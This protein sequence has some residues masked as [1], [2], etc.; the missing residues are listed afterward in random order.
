MELPSEYSSWTNLVICI[1]M[2]WRHFLWTEARFDIL[3]AVKIQVDVL[4]GVTPCSV[5]TEGHCHCTNTFV[6][7]QNA[8]FSS[9]SVF[10]SLKAKKAHRKQ[11][12]RAVIASGVQLAPVKAWFQIFW[13]YNPKRSHHHYLHP[14]QKSK[15]LICRNVKVFFTHE[16][17]IHGITQILFK[18]KLSLCLTR[19]RTMKTHWGV[20]VWLHAFYIS[21]LDE[22]EWSASRPGRLT[23]RW[24]APVSIGQEAGWASEPFWTRWWSCVRTWDEDTRRTEA[25]EIGSLS[26]G[27]T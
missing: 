21:A 14:T 7:L 8:A 2:V 3:T 13:K 19:H 5:M 16:E 15:V 22:D 20:E 11:A 24:R 10:R 1:A 4:W 17:H 6:I 9:P 18:V 23:H 26:P 25:V 27:Y 12:A